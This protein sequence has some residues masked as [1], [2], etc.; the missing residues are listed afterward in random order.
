[1]DRTV[2]DYVPIPVDSGSAY[3][4]GDVVLRLCVVTMVGAAERVR[5]RTSVAESRPNRCIESA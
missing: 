3:D 4:G 2:Q 1:V 5:A